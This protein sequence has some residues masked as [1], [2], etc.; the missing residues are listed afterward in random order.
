MFAERN[1]RT[2]ESGRN[3]KWN[4][5]LGFL[6][7]NAPGGCELIFQAREFTSGNGESRQECSPPYN[8][9][10]EIPKAFFEHPRAGERHT[11]F[12]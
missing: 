6:R 7:M 5:C 8:K 10:L 12:C 4:V 1:T 3:G 11:M 9:Q 2:G